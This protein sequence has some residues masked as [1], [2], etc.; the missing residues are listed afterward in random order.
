MA[1][2]SS[3]RRNRYEN[4]FKRDIHRI[5]WH[6]FLNWVFQIQ[7]TKLCS[8]RDVARIFMLSCTAYNRDGHLV[9]TMDW[10]EFIEFHA[11]VGRELDDGEVGEEASDLKRFWRV[12]EYIKYKG[13]D[14]LNRIGNTAGGFDPDPTEVGAN[15]FI[16]KSKRWTLPIQKF[17]RVM[18][19]YDG[20]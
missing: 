8:V 6:E 14:L 7:L 12:M 15:S 20:V 17:L 9:L 18:D 2:G 4:I 10:K 19:R 13:F 11:R 16:W 5:E 1:P 3:S